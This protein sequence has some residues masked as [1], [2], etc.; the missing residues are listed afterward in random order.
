VKCI[1]L[2]LCFGFALSACKTY[3]PITET[4]M[5]SPPVSSLAELAS[6]SVEARHE[7]R[8]LAKA[9][10]A[11]AQQE[12]TSA[13]HE[14]RFR[15]ATYVPPGF[16]SL[17][18]LNYTGPARQA[19]QAIALLAGYEIAYYGNPT[20]NEPFVHIDI[21]ARPLNEALKELGLQT[22]D[23]IRVE[24]HPAAKLMRFIYKP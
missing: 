12:M 5:V 15:Q 17:V 3:E 24:L 13:Q 9:Q 4:I 21:D 7:L 18:Q 16:E 20:S 22:G 2:V 10:E 6:L 23:A 19:A 8:L 11:L 14:E 1:F